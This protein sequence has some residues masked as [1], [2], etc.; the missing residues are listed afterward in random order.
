MRCSKNRWRENCEQEPLI[1]SL[2]SH[3]KKLNI[4]FMSK[5]QSCDKVESGN[6]NY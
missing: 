4:Y 5:M 6:N 2:V 1:L 3:V